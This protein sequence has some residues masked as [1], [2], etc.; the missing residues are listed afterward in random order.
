MSIDI[1]LGFDCLSEGLQFNYLEVAEKYIQSWC[2]QNLFPLIIRSSYKGD[3]K[4]NWR[5]Q[6]SCPHGIQRKSKAK[7]ERPLQH[8]QYS[9]CPAMVNV[10]QNRQANCWRVTEVE[11]RHEGHMIGPAICSSYQKARK[12]SNEDLWSWSLLV[13]PDVESR[14]HS[15]TRQEMCTRQRMST[16]HLEG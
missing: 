4:H 15:V 8:V 13:H 10:V 2:D 3:E 6:Y 5:I 11:K 16:M 12:M 14:L 1:D 9:A 7:G